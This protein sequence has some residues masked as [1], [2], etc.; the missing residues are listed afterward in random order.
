MVLT[1]GVKGNTWIGA[2]DRAKE[3]EW[4]WSSSGKLFGVEANLTMQEAKN[5][6]SMRM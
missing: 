6:V 5:T 1:L 3:G 4:R 2:T